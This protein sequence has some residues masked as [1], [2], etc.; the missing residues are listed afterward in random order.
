MAEP[1]HKNASP[2]FFFQ[3]IETISSDVVKEWIFA[4]GAKAAVP[5]G[6]YINKANERQ[7]AVLGKVRLWKNIQKNIENKLKDI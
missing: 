2:I 1:Q 6:M 4:C 3:M 7:M 5:L